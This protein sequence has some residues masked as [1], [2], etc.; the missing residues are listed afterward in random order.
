MLFTLAL[1]LSASASTAGWYV[2]H[3]DSPKGYC[4]LY[5]QPSTQD[6]VSRNLGRYDNGEYVYVLEY[7]GGN[8]L[9]CYASKA[10][11]CKQI[12]RI[13]REE[14]LGTDCV[15]LGELYTALA[16]GFDPENICYHGNNKT[17]S[18]LKTVLKEGVGRIVCD[19]LNKLRTRDRLCTEGAVTHHPGYL[20]TYPRICPDRSV[21]FQIRLCT[22]RRLCAGSGKTGGFFGALKLCR[23]A[24]PY[25]QPDLRC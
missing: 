24:L 23:C 1:P 8:G 16:V 19:N 6:G 2:V 14:G 5:S 13:V 15:S 10:F 11:C 12:Y 21:R 18:E 17:K 22:R 9:V 4:Y 7:Y 3:S 20:R 25:R